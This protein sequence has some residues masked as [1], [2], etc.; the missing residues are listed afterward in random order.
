MDFEKIDNK[1]DEVEKPFKL[2]KLST[3]GKPKK[4]VEFKNRKKYVDKDIIIEKIDKKIQ[5]LEE[6]LLELNQREFALY[7]DTINEKI[8]NYKELKELLEGE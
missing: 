4:P 6:E 8:K 2:L 7:E 1:I 5:E 3:F